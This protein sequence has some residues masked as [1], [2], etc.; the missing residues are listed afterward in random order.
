M[1]LIG[2]GSFSKVYRKSNTTVLIK[3]VDPVKECMALDW[4]PSSRL[5]P[6]VNRTGC[7]EYEMKYYPKVSSLKN[8]LKPKHY[9][10][11]N[12][13]RKI[14]GVH[15]NPLNP[16]DRFDAWYKAFGKISCPRKRNIMREAL[17]ACTNF[18]TDVCFE[19]S[20]RNVAVSN[21]NLILLDCFYMQSELNK[22]QSSR[23]WQEVY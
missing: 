14:Y 7:G 15:L 16:Y 12:E 6:K 9:A 4:F 10:F 5:F 20:P 3:S 17:G 19:I 23:R 13:L 21:G 22:V 18:G 8:T 11:Y 1:K 2:K